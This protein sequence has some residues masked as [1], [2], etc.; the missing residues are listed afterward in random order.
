MPMIYSWNLGIQR[1]L[2]RNLA[3]DLSYVGT[4][5]THLMVQRA[6]NGT[7]VGYFLA[8]PNALPSV[9]NFTDA[10]RPYRGFGSLTS[11]ETSGTSSYHAMLVRLSRRFTN[12]FGFNVN[13]TWSRTFDIVDNDS[14]NLIDPLNIRANWAPAGY[15]VTHSLTIDYV[16]QFPNVRGRLDNRF[17][18][19]LLNDWQISGV[20]H[21]QTGFPITVFANGNLLGIDAGPAGQLADLIGDPYAGQTRDHWLN[22]AAFARPLDGRQGTLHRNGLRGPGF[23]NWD[24]SLS[25]IIRFRETMDLKIGMDVFNV[26]NHP[27]VWAINTGFAGD[28]PGSGISSST[29][30]TFGT[31]SQFRDPRILQFG[32]RFQ[33]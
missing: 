23:G 29:R 15:D 33:F 27:Q 25:R 28:N 13:Y 3:L 32:F 8:N 16:Y 14:D 18:R 6:I 22:P 4:R 2:A 1:E 17:G 20:T 26:F 5:G 10:L 11:I 19:A 9:N 31:V 21:Y 24:V 30:G 7:P 12:R